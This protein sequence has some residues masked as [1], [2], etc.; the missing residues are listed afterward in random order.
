MDIRKFRI[1]VKKHPD[2]YVVYPLGIKKIIV[3]EGDTYEKVLSDI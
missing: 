1:I 3:C 2:G